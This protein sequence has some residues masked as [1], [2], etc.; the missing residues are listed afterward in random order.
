[1]KKKYIRH[2]KENK[3]I[4]QF[5][6]KLEEKQYKIQNRVLIARYRGKTICN[7]C[8][9]TRLRKDALFKLHKKYC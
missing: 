2:G 5:F 9:G 8:N 7:T 3:G 6:K 4:N 1:M